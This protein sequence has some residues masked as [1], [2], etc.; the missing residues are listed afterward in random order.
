MTN[1]DL[2]TAL[3]IA[4]FLLQGGATIVAVVWTI[5][6]I[7]ATTDNLRLEIKHLAEAVQGVKNWLTDVDK[8]AHDHESR[9][10]VVESNNHCNRRDDS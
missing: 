8:I 2:K 1:D 10:R 6:K 3:T 7:S 9:L 4:A 5:A